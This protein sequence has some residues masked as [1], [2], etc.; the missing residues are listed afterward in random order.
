MIKCLNSFILDSKQTAL[1]T[2]LKEL[3]KEVNKSKSL[4]KLFNKHHLKNGIYLYGPVGSGKTLLMNSFF[5]A[6]SISKTILHYQNFIHEMHKSMHRLQTEK[7]KDIITKIAKNYAK[8]T[9]VLCIDEFEIKDITDAMIISRLFNELIKQ[10]IFIFIT[11]NTSPNNLYKDGLQRESFL[12][13]IKTIN[14]TFYIKYLDNHHDYRFDKALGVKSSRIIYPLT[15]ENK[16]K[17]KK[18]IMKISDNNLVAQNIQVLC[19]SISFQKVYKQILV[20]D[21]NELFI[22]ELSYIDYV[23]ICQNFNI[24]IVE[25][26]NTI[27]ANDTDTVVRFI[28]FID[29]AYF[30]KILLFMSLVD[31]PNKIYQG[32]ARAKEFQR[33]ISRLHEMNS[34]AYL[35]NNDLKELI[36]LNTI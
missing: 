22:R 9:K 21:Y 11:S 13:F 25:N 36:T 3:A 4:F 35:L 27:D 12:P 29:N 5:D 1:L 30:Y 26:I 14:N 2:E 6:I 18:I 31:N 23:N 19:R 15:L 28:N 10:N 34:E 33:A 24:I 20:T 32:L 16:N 8:Q 7:Q 17:L